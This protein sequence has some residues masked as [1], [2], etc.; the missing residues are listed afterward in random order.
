MKEFASNLL[1][2]ARAELERRRRPEATY[3]LQL[4][5]GFTFKDATALLPYLHNLGITDCYL[6]PF[7]KARPGSS[8]GYDITDHNQLNPEIGT[9]EDYAAWT[10]ALKAHGMGQILDIVPNHMAVVG[11][12][13]LWWNDVLENGPA[14]PYALYFDIDWHSSSRTQLDGRVLIPILGEAYGQVLESQQL[15]LVY[16]AG[17]FIVTYFDHRFPVAPRSYGLILAQ[18]LAELQNRLGVEA[19]PFQEYQSILTAIKHLPRTQ[20]TEP[21]LLAERL[22]EKEI[23]KRRLGALTGQSEEVRTCIGNIVTRFNGQ[24]GVPESFDLLEE[25][26]NDQLYRLA[27]WR[28]AAD[29]INYRRFFDINELAALSMDRPEVFAAT[30]GLILRLLNDDTVTGLRIDHVDGLYDPQRY[31]GRLQE[32]AILSRGRYQF[33]RQ[34]SG[35]KPAW[36]ELEPELSELLRQARQGS[37]PEVSVQRPLYV[38]VEKILIGDEK[39]PEYWPVYGT[40]GYD[41]LNIVNRLFVAEKNG[42]EFTSLYRAWTGDDSSLQELVYR[43]KVLVLQTALSG[44]LEMLSHQLDR[45]AQKNRLSRD[46]TR[47]SLR[48]AIREI[49]ACFPVYR[50]YICEGSITDADHKK[51]LRAVIR[52]RRRNPAL[53]TALFQ[54]I[55]DMLLSQAGMPG[56]TNAEARDFGNKFQQ[57]AAP[58]MAKGFEDTVFYVYNR[59]LS[60]NEVGGAPDQFGAEPTAVHQAMAERQAKWP[61]S[62]SASSTHDT[63]RG[64]DVRARLDALSEIPAEWNERLRHWSSLNQKHK[65]VLEDQSVPDPNEE[66]ALYQTLVGAWPFQPYSETELASFASRIQEFTRKALQEAKVHTSWINPNNAYDEAMQEFIRRILDPAI[67][68]DFLSDFLP[69]QKRLSDAGIYNSLAQTLLSI[70]APGVADFY[71]CTELWSSS[72]VDPDNRRPVNFAARQ[73]LQAFLSEADD[74]DGAARLDLLRRLMQSKEDGA[75]KM[76]LIA[77]AL[78]W[79]REHPGLFSTGGLCAGSKRRSA[80]LTCLRFRSVR[81]ERSGNDR[82]SASSLATGERRSPLRHGNLARYRSTSARRGERSP[83][84]QSPDGRKAGCRTLGKWLAPDHG[85]RAREFPGGAA[86]CGCVK[87]LARAQLACHN[88][89][90]RAVSEGDT[91]NN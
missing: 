78:G 60:L 37:G 91:K 71:L 3:R 20:E 22:R 65:M 31:L 50:S 77:T 85:A 55:S 6:S 61:W 39:L 35:E 8:H 87:E 80:R 5:K 17:T 40:T 51:V 24:A 33:D 32:Q 28:V 75:I 26:L 27:N 42:Q 36:E 29:E 12:D 10:A 11:N 83:L 7:L 25:L 44:E 38:L 89:T 16:E 63:K 74:D 18:G 34:R 58:V 88:S 23:I 41:F 86:G 47:H 72:L 49:I 45:L 46:F 1:E 62:L 21:A 53:S 15:R 2:Q 76:Y 48:H 90:W 69:F 57:V 52:A 82:G 84:E 81:L 19:S 13:N 70:A 43:K 73:K 79:R 14:S 9:E 56:V 68:A 30:H 64:E 59:L 4:H 66:Y 67:A 54:F